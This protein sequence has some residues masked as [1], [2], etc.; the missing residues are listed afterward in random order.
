M[1]DRRERELADVDLL[2]AGVGEGGWLG[3]TDSTTTGTNLKRI[4][5][6]APLLACVLVEKSKRWE[7]EEIQGCSKIMECFLF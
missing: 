3:C 5:G 2:G 6:V 1:E 4:N 7:R